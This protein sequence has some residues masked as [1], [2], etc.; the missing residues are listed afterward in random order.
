MPLKI[1]KNANNRVW[2]FKNFQWS[3]PRTP[4]SGL[5]LHPSFCRLYASWRVTRNVPDEA[6]Q[7]SEALEWLLLDLADLPCSLIQDN[8][9]MWYYRSCL[10][11]VWTKPDWLPTFCQNEKTDWKSRLFRSIVCHR[12]VPASGDSTQHLFAGGSLEMYQVHEPQKNFANHAQQGA[13]H[14]Q[15]TVTNVVKEKH[16]HGARFLQYFDKRSR[17]SEAHELV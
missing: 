14:S 4:L 10:F 13:G 2:F 17:K 7:L 15:G 11:H 8:V 1:H 9:S 3:T 12:C 6:N 5:G 16:S